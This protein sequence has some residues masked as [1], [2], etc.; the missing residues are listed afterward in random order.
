MLKGIRENTGGRSVGD[1]NTKKVFFKE[2]EGEEG[3][4]IAVDLS[5][6]PV[7]SWKDRLL[8]KRAS[9]SKNFFHKSSSLFQLKDFEN[10]YF[11]AK[12][13]SS[14]DYEKVLTQGPWIMFGQYLIVQP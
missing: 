2:M 8:G 1:R 11:L 6:K 12:F 5:S 3:I 7:L 10:D 13:Q 9:E 4:E 14:K